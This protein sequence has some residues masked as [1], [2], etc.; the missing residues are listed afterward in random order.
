MERSRLFGANFP[1]FRLEA[2]KDSTKGQYGIRIN[3]Q[4]RICFQWRDGDVHDVEL[5][6]DH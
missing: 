2:R 4:Y 1:G 3:D 6:D 5:V